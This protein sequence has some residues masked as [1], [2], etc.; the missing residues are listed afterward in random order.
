M[1]SLE[2][3]DWTEAGVWR[4]FRDALHGYCANLNSHSAMFDRSSHVNKVKYFTALTQVQ[5]SY[6]AAHARTSFPVYHHL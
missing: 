3:C 1:L 6:I 2:T 5:K 4:R